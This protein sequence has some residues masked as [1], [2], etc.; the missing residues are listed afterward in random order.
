MAPG[1][2]ANPEN[3]GTDD[4]STSLPDQAHSRETRI[5]EVESDVFEHVYTLAQRDYR[6][7]RHR[8]FFRRSAGI[9]LLA[10]SAA[11]CASILI[12]FLFLKDHLHDLYAELAG[13]GAAVAALNHELQAIHSAEEALK[14]QLDEYR[15][16]MG[17]L[18]IQDERI[19]D[20]DL[21]PDVES[22]AA[23]M[24]RTAFEYRNLRRGPTHRKELALTFD[25]G[26]GRELEYV[27]K[28]LRQS[29]AR[30]TIFL[31]NEVP[32]D[33]YGSLISRDNLDNL[34]RLA[35][36]G[37]EFGNHTWSHY[38]L[39]RSL[40]ETSRRRRLSLTYLSD[41]VLDDAG[42]AREFDM[43]RRSM[44]N[45]GIPMSNLW[46]APYGAYDRRILAAAAGMG[47]TT[48]VMWS[49]NRLGPLDFYDYVYKRTVL[50]DEDGDGDFER[51]PNPVY[52]TS[53][54]MLGRMKR[55]EQV[56]PHGLRGAI[57]I[58]HLGTARRF[59]RITRI[60]PDFIAYCHDRGYRF[61]TVSELMRD[62]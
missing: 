15:Q 3:K 28:V 32:A 11:G 38:N 10:L 40:Y 47:Y 56:D 25:M 58:A 49:G 36:L 34:R 21:A 57:A 14:Q 27:Y 41:T 43:V 44:L 4:L 19:V 61:V 12:F 59:D 18:T 54:Q 5:T 9:I 37:C 42:L 2:G 48:H 1:Q 26:T 16:F 31:S 6:R 51:V 23:S 24:D 55:W 39:R 62:E 53:E 17:R 35:D 50:R 46:R 8:A 30:A 45:E 29:G 20:F 52:Y 7:L 13:Y 22:A 60:L 33:G